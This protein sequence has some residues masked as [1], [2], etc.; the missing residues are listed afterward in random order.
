M[1]DTAPLRWYHRSMFIRR[2]TVRNGKTAKNYSYLNLVESVRTENGPR[3]RLVLNLG[4]L[5][6]DR[7]QYKTLAR[8]IEDML[9]GK[10]SLFEI[11]PQIEQHAKWAAEKIFAR[12]AEE[13]NGEEGEEYQLVDT[14][15]LAVSTPRSLG[16]E[17]VCH[18]MWQKLDFPGVLTRS[19]IPQSTLP[20]LEALVL[21]RLISPGS[22]LWTR[23]WGEE[24]DHRHGCR[25]RHGSEYHM[26]QGA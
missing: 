19:G 13:L 16:A 6:I 2:V 11:D 22:E 10:R 17:Y 20:L 5:P 26:A 23:K 12:R 8:R 1:V 3:Q 24:R 7:S 14:K 21:G 9:S 25:D 18:S 15:S 4:D